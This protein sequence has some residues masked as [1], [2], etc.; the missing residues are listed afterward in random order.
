MYLKFQAKRVPHLCGLDNDLLAFTHA[1]HCCISQIEIPQVIQT[2]L[3]EFTQVIGLC[4]TRNLREIVK[5]LNNDR[6]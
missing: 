4:S 2:A 6:V 1:L 3:D 5:T